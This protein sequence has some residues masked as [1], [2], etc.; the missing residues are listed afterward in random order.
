MIEASPPARRPL[1][2][3]LV[4][5]HFFGLAALLLWVCGETRPVPM[6]DLQWDAGEKLRCVSYAPFHRPGQTPF[7]EKQTISRQQIKEDL[8]AL[9]AITDCVRLYATDAGL[10]QTPSVARELGLEVLLGAWIGHD[11]KKNARELERAIALAN[12]YRDVVRALIVGNEVLLRQERRPEEMR[13]LLAS[14]RA[15][16]AV[17]VTYAD[18]WEFWLKNAELVD[19]VDFVT[20]HILPF[21]EDEPVDIAR[22]LDH[23]ADI[24]AKVGARFSGKPVLIG[25]TGWPSVGRQRE[26]S[27]PSRVNQARY[28][29]EFV[30]L[31]HA[32]AWDY[33][34]I[35]AIDQP[36]KRAL[37]GTVGGYWGMLRAGDL[38]PKFPL[39][40]ALAERD[41]L[42]PPLVGAAAGAALALL[43]AL[44]GRLRALICQPWRLAAV[45]V[46]GATIGLIAVLHAEHALL[47]YTTLTDWVALGATALAA[48][49]VGATFARWQGEALIP[50]ENAWRHI[51]R[52]IRRKHFAVD[53]TD[54]LSALYGFFLFA[55]AVA[56]LLLLV[57]P[58]YR[59]FASLLYLTPAAIYGVIGWRRNGFLSLPER[60]CATVV[61]VCAVGRWALEP[62]NPQ[63]IGW[64]LTMLALALPSV[65]WQIVRLCEGRAIPQQG[66]QTEQDAGGGVIGAIE[67]QPGHTSEPAA[68]SEAPPGK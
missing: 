45:T 23:V 60:I 67:D 58:R 28:I 52:G 54:I 15:A 24:R 1:W 66:E 39:T 7:D 27:R 63:A 32:Q 20:V 50:A 44:I 57:T 12:E 8:M 4:F 56:A 34:L 33:N 21:W 29:R 41:S 59:D 22:A 38:Q 16:S 3:A 35:E 46:C 25:E 5:V 48:L 49:L 14:A 62:A 47:A 40:G 51:W 19:A 37:E 42:A 53:A 10:D 43:F 55:A 65:G 13:A 17:P 18:V 36:W 30:R 64:L 68:P 9:S 11:R 26:A 61:A 2:V 31:A 6:H